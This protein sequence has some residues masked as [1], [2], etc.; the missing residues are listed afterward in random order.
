[1]REKRSIAY[2]RNDC[3]FWFWGFAFKKPCFGFGG[4]IRMINVGVIGL[5]RMGMLHLMNCLKIDDVNVVAAADALKKA[6][7]RANS[8]GVKTVAGAERGG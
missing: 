6:L 7:S 8:L 4:K 1:M 3:Y 5:G 2:G